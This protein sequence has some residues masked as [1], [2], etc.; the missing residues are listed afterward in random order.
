MTGE[1]TIA[2]FAPAGASWT[3]FVRGR[4]PYD[5][6]AIDLPVEV[7]GCDAWWDMDDAE[8]GRV[9]GG[10]LR[11]AV[12]RAVASVPLYRL[13]P[14]WQSVCVAD[15]A[16]IADLASLPL[17]A[18][19]TV[20]GMPLTG[21]R[22]G[23]VANPYDLVPDDLGQVLRRQERAN[24]RYA[25]ILRWY[26]NRIVLSFQSRG[27]QGAQT[28]TIETYL[29]VEMEAHALARCLRRNGFRPGQRIACLHPSDRKGGLQLARAALLM[30]M[31]FHGRESIMG[32]LEHIPCYA[33]AFQGVREA[34]SRGDDAALERHAARIRQGIR[35]YI[36]ANSIRVVEAAEPPVDAITCGP[37]AAPLAFMSLYDESPG[38]FAWVEHVFLGAFPVPRAAWERL[39]DDGKPVSTVWSAIEGASFATGTIR[40]ADMSG[41]PNEL[42]AAWFPTAGFV[43]DGHS[44]SG[45]RASH[46]VAPGGTGLLTVT[47]LIG[48]GTTCLNHVVGD[49]ATRTREGFR[50]IARAA[51]PSGA[52]G[53]PLDDALAL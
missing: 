32:T 33:E 38:S 24:A 10:L 49:I 27:S 12:R 16:D 52:R 46:A 21:I 41:D 51:I 45:G 36:R 14:A 22:E 11:N 19:D 20:P 47:G 17:T 6:D 5:L 34:R 1:D 29:T 23:I 3:D 2:G 53:A 25:D 30:G 39:R 9:L 37:G 43:A 48:G 8:R 18:R 40:T 50:D 7:A 42:S 28:R 44:S 26:G 15:I 13:D 35:E 4:D 31:P